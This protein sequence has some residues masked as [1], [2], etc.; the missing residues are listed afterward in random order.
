MSPKYKL[1][2]QRLM[3]HEKIFTFVNNLNFFTVNL[4][5]SVI[6]GRLRTAA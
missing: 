4:K 2:V 6:S 5:K 3:A 1:R